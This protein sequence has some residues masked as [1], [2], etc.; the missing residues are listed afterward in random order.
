MCALLA[1]TRPLMRPCG[2]PRQAHSSNEGTGGLR[3]F[4]Y[5]SIY[6]SHVV[7]VHHAA[8][9][10]TLAG[11]LDIRARGC[12]RCWCWWLFWVNIWDWCFVFGWRRL[13]SASDVAFRTRRPRTSSAWL[14]FD[15]FVG[16]CFFDN[17]RLGLSWHL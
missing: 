5:R 11:C 1:N 6:I 4:S 15:V 2:L 8:N 10:G 12:R 17:P 3:C 14:Y 16:F 13:A 9:G 7:R